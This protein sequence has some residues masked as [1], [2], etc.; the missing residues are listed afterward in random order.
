MSSVVRRVQGSADQSSAFSMDVSLQPA[1]EELPIAVAVLDHN[2]CIIAAS[3]ACRRL[4]PMPHQARPDRI[5]GRPYLSVYWAGTAEA[6]LVAEGLAQL[7]SNRRRHFRLVCQTAPANGASRQ[8]QLRAS[9]YSTAGGTR[10]LIVCEDITLRKR[11][12]AEREALSAR[13]LQAQDLERQ[14]IAREL[15]DSTAQ[16]LAAIGLGLARL[17]PLE[18][19]PETASTLADIRE[20]LAYAHQDIRALTYRL[21]PPPPEGGSLLPAIRHYA[22]GFS[23]RTGLQV[24]LP[25]TFD[26]R[27]LSQEVRMALFRVSQEALANVYK[28]AAARR[29]WIR[30]CKRGEHIRLEVEDDGKG[31]AW[32]DGAASHSALGIGI[33]SMSARMREIGGCLRIIPTGN[34]TLVTADTR[35]RSCAKE[36]SPI[37]CPIAL[38]QGH[39]RRE[40][41]FR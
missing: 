14:R 17:G 21:H 29:V 11:I 4:A 5:I 12:K 41:K 2:G 35:S 15:H 20:A 31:F 18:R 16:H 37:P 10:L 1:L 40:A 28:H 32:E 26:C 3:R 7:L 9:R 6:P 38:T 23:G 19:S 24:M 8:F 33:A 34:G 25:E 13:L 30:L 36:A 39:H 27:G 22:A